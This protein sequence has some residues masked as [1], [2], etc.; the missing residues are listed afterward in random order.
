[1]TRETIIAEPAIARRVVFIVPGKP[2]GKGRPHFAR[3]GAHV[4]AFTPEATER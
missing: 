2:V 4:R 3:C 1:M